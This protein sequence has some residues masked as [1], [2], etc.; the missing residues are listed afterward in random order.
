VEEV[1]VV[2]V[3]EDAIM[4][5]TEELVLEKDLGEWVLMESG[6]QHIR[7]KKAKSTPGLSMLKISTMPTMRM[8]MLLLLESER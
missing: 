8:M 6:N 7:S 4:Q 1:E 2:E 5:V 3:E